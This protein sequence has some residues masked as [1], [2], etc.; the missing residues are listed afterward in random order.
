ME[1]LC[2]GADLGRAMFTNIMHPTNLVLVGLIIVLAQLGG[3]VL[4]TGVIFA[5]RRLYP[6]VARVSA[7]SP[8]GAAAAR[9]LK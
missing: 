9:W 2:A 6:A 1:F 7:S 5:A 8:P 4:I 3:L